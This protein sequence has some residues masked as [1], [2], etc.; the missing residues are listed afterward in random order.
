M[1]AWN[2]PTATP[3]DTEPK[4]LLA[5]ARGSTSSNSYDNGYREIELTDGA[6]AA[7]LSVNEPGLPSDRSPTSDPDNTQY[8]SSLGT[9]PINFLYQVP[10]AIDKNMPVFA[11][12][13]LNGLWSYKDRGDGPEWNAEE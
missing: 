10:Y 8:V 6:L 9:H 13:Q 5:G 2:N 12:T 3:A 1:A 7:P 4:L 11:S